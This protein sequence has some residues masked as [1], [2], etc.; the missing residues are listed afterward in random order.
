MANRMLRD[1]GIGGSPHTPTEHQLQNN[2]IKRYSL[3]SKTWRTKSSSRDLSKQRF[4]G[5]QVVN[6]SAKKK[7]PQTCPSHPEHNPT[8]SALKRSRAAAQEQV[9]RE[10]VGSIGD[11]QLNSKK[12]MPG[13]RGVMNVKMVGEVS[14]ENQ[15]E[16]TRQ[17]G[18]GA[19]LSDVVSSAEQ[20][21]Q[22]QNRNVQQRTSAKMK[23]KENKQT[24]KKT[25]KTDS[26]LCR[27]C[28]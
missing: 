22:E 6:N 8:F 16:K 28:T 26:V 12:R 15:M 2:R 14:Q 24:N 9:R 20:Q 17:G 7:P 5:N 4:R 25:R 18:P 3:Q 19:G 13:G 11:G 1:A 23:T 10:R 21:W 27:C